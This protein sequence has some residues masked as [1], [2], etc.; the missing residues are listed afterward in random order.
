MKFLRFFIITSFVVLL[1]ACGGA[2]ERKAAY[3]EKAE[4]SIKAGDLK[5]RVLS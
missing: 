4:Q 1:M 2:E 5:K 3:L